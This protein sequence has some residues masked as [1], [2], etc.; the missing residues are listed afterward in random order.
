MK[1]LL[2]ITAIMLSNCIQ[3]PN[4]EDDIFNVYKHRVDLHEDFGTHE[5]AYYEHTEVEVFID[6]NLH[7]YWVDFEVF[8]FDV[9]TTKIK[10]L[11][12]LVE[13]HSWIGGE[14]LYVDIYSI[15]QDYRNGSERF[16]SITI[17]TAY[18]VQ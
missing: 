18:E 12:L 13:K 7:H 17:N 9:K 3:A 4:S 15:Y 14:A 16:K 6:A 11:P 1:Y 10:R 8:D 2:L 5:L